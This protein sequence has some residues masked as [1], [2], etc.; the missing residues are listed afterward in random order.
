MWVA[1]EA[2]TLTTTLL[3]AFYQQK[4]SLEAAWKYIVLCSTGISLGLVGFCSHSMPARV[5]P[6]SGSRASIGPT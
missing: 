2:T 1:L 5:R 6:S 3:V 4:G